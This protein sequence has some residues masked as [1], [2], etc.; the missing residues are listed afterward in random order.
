MTEPNAR[1]AHYYGRMLMRGM[2][3]QI[4][5]LQIRL[6]FDP[7]ADAKAINREIA[8]LSRLLRRFPPGMRPLAALR[9]KE[10]ARPVSG[11]QARRNRDVALRAQ[12]PEI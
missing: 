3:N 9:H 11:R 8:A 6:A 5:K 1:R 7:S 10:E 12:T 2:L 4:S